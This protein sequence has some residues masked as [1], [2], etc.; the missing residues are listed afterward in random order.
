MSIK[1]NMTNIT[2]FVTVF[3]VCA[4]IAA[5]AP[6]EVN[7]VSASIG[8]VST[9]VGKIVLDDTTSYKVTAPF[10]MTLG[11]GSD[12][13]GFSGSIVAKTN[14]NPACTGIKTIT[15]EG[16]F[17]LIL[18]SSLT[19]PITTLRNFGSMGVK[20]FQ[21]FV[22]DITDIT[23][24]GLTITADIDVS[25]VTGDVDIKLSEKVGADKQ[26]ILELLG[27]DLTFR[28]ALS[29]LR[30]YEKGVEMPLY[31]IVE[32]VKKG[33]MKLPSSLC[34]GRKQNICGANCGFGDAVCGACDELCD[35]AGSAIDAVMDGTDNPAI[36]EA[37][38]NVAKLLDDVANAAGADLKG[39]V[40]NCAAASSKKCFGI[41]TAE[42][43]PEPE[44]S[45]AT[46][47]H[48]NIFAIAA[49][50]FLAFMQ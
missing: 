9:S 1:T 41:G 21:S 3:A 7:K 48:L 49:V 47:L 30:L 6:I 29:E 2:L 36:F 12:E 11:S 15:I 42:K 44:L 38:Y 24:N 26:K 50:A 17:K 43:C 22:P 23:D 13:M 8:G 18:P 45:G 35:A 34:G 27:T 46:Q 28:I 5:S 32:I 4:S 14:D 39:T 16:S 31:I 37:E 40:R 20:P 19:S 33:S 25:A 10:E